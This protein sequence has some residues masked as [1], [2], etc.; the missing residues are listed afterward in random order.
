MKDMRT[1]AVMGVVAPELEEARVAQRWP[2]VTTASGLA[3]LGS[4]LQKSILLA[5]LGWLLLAP[6]Y[7][8]KILPFLATRYTLTNRRIMIQKGL[9]PTPAQAP[10]CT[11]TTSSGDQHASQ[12][13]FSPQNLPPY[14]PAIARAV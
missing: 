8:K 12:V 1:H 10:S 11:L 13:A 2:S 6:L 3:R 14:G 9:K 5:P 4:S 7:F